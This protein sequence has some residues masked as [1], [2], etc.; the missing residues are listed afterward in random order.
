MFVAL[1]FNYIFLLLWV[2]IDPPNSH[3]TTLNS[4]FISASEHFDIY[5]WMKVRKKYILNRKRE[6]EVNNLTNTNPIRVYILVCNWI[7]ILL[8]IWF[9][10]FLGLGLIIAGWL[11]PSR[12]YANEAPTLKRSTIAERKFCPQ[13]NSISLFQIRAAFSNFFQKK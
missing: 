13:W 1:L 6:M 5:D 4:I 12:S 7:G 3:F 9:S 2:M 8:L 10:L 11:G